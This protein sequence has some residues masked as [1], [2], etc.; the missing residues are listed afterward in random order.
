MRNTN[1]I[2]KLLSMSQRIELNGKKAIRVKKQALSKISGLW[3][4]ATSPVITAGNF[5]AE[6]ASSF[7]EEKQ[8]AFDNFIGEEKAV[9][10]EN[11]NVGIERDFQ[12][13]TV[14]MRK[15]AKNIYKDDSMLEEDKEIYLTAVNDKLLKLK[16]DKAK[17][18]NSGL[19]VFALGKLAVNKLRTNAIK[20]QELKRAEKEAL[21]KE[22][23][24]KQENILKA[25]E[26]EAEAVRLEKEKY[27]KNSRLKQL[28]EAKKQ[29]EQEA[30]NRD[31]EIEALSVELGMTQSVAEPI[32]FA[33]PESEQTFEYEGSSRAK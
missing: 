20:A 17:K 24:I 3:K 22:E 10:I 27:A 6:K 30:I 14:D 32:M 13:K 1:D 15:T 19:G 4:K 28:L 16:S 31:L 25:Q 8:V 23:A 9:E 7:I 18:I 26:L 2:N 29:A 11:R 21:L 33:E 12:A 5:V